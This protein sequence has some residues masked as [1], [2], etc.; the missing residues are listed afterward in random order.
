LVFKD[1]YRRLTKQLYYYNIYL[2]L[3]QQL[4]LKYLMKL[5]VDVSC[6]SATNNNISRILSKGQHPI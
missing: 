1:H 3:S 2:L 6:L 4:F 5:L